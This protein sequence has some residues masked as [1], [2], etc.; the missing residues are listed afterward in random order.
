VSRTEEV[1]DLAVVIYAIMFIVTPIESISLYIYISYLKI[2]KQGISITFWVDFLILGSLD[3][4]YVHCV[5]GVI[6]IVL[7]FFITFLVHF[8]IFS[9]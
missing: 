8:N 7:N 3:I 9:T 6:F 2:K 1:E 4:S 5:D